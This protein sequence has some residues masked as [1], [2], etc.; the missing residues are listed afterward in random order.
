MFIVSIAT[1][2]LAI[3]SGYLQYREKVE[4][5]EKALKKEIELNSVYKKLER[6][7][8]EIIDLKSEVIGL[9]TGGD[10]YCEVIILPLPEKTTHAQILLKHHGK[11]PLFDVKL[12]ITDL[13]ILAN[14]VKARGTNVFT[15][16]EQ[17]EFSLRFECST[18]LPNSIIAQGSFTDSYSTIDK[19]SYNIFLNARNGIQYQLIRLFKKDKKWLSGT[20]IFD[21]NYNIKYE[22][23]DKNIPRELFTWDF[24]E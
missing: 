22:N 11:Y 20:I 4:S 6:K 23:I 9:T 7:S 14:N 15:I 17:A 12:T 5:S 8:D 18:L 3:T 19:K 13:D 24:K 21:K 2:I 16:D 10:S 1:A